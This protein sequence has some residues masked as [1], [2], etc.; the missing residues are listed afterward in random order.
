MYLCIHSNLTCIWNMINIRLLWCIVHFDI[1]VEIWHK[2]TVLR[3]TSSW[4]ALLTPLLDIVLMLD[5]LFCHWRHLV[6]LQINKGKENDIEICLLLFWRLSTDDRQNLGFCV[7][8]ERKTSARNELHHQFTTQA[9]YH[10]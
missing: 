7:S 1:Q 3:S 8:L 6:I 10:C 5:I 2:T 9:P 4:W